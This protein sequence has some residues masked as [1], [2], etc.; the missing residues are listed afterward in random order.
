M[1]EP[2][3]IYEDKRFLAVDKPAGLLVHRVAISA[4]QKAQREETLVDW[5]LKKYPELKTVGDDPTTR[6]G[7]V[8]RLDRDTSGIMLIPRNQEYFLY[9][10][11]LFSEHKVIK[12]Y[13]ALVWGRVMP[14]AG[15]VDRPIG[16]LSGSVKRS[17]HSTKM[18][19]EAITAYRVKKYLAVLHE[20]TTLVE[21]IPKTGRTHQ[22]RIHL[23]SLGH[24]IV[25]DMLYGKKVNLRLKKQAEHQGL[26]TFPARQLLHAESLEFSPEPGTHLTLGAELPNDFV[27]M[28]GG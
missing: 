11:S 3:I 25:G 18:Q 12:K 1:Q 16:I 20:A 19:K 28:L 5:L 7:I 15:V 13:L 17:L 14:E 4:K 10:K 8:H 24:P 21:L 2:K 22:L 26:K 9:L 23:A 6:P 27:S